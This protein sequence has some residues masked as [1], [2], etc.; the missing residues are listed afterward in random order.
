MPTLTSVS[1]ELVQ[2]TITEYEV[3]DVRQ[4]AG[5]N[6]TAGRV[7]QDIINTTMGW[8]DKEE[9]WVSRTIGAVDCTWNDDRHSWTYTYRVK[10]GQ[11]LI[12]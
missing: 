5:N 11:D 3:N 2:I 12:F 6:P 7:V 4:E 9:H 10:D 8:E 1:P